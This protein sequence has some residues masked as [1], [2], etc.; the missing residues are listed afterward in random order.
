MALVDLSLQHPPSHL[1]LLH[2]AVPELKYMH[3]VTSIL[4][5]VQNK[6]KMVLLND[7][8]HSHFKLLLQLYLLA[9]YSMM[10]LRTNE[11]NLRHY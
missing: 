3:P 1:S 7:F 2:L 9:R 5:L 4:P 11:T 8:A 6:Q 10:A